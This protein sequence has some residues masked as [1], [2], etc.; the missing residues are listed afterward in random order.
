MHILL[1]DNHDSFTWNLSHDLER[2]GADVMVARAEELPVDEKEQRAFLS[3]FVAVVLS[4][5]A[6]MPAEAPMLMAVLD[7]CVK[8]KKPVLGV[9][10]GF[11]AI[12]EYF[13]G[14]L[15]NMREVLHGRVGRM[16]LSEQYDKKNGLFE[17]VQFPCEVAHYHSWVAKEETLP[18]V[19]MVEARTEQGMILA[20]RHKSLPISG[21]QFHPE[22][23]LTPDGR[24]MLSNWLN[25]LKREALTTDVLP[26]QR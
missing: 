9:C 22:S 25:A 6:G 23:V 5:G 1:F 8:N 17:N 21:F 2:A 20:L 18:Q 7:F 24:V 10:L 16:I 14:E 12:V 26:F 4:P 19:L 11:Q 15:E 13:G 3:Q